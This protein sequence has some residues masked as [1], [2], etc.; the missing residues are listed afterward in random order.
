MILTAHSCLVSR[1][2]QRWTTDVAPLSTHAHTTCIM[3]CL[4]VYLANF[5]P[6]GFF[7]S[8]ICWT[9][10]PWTICPFSPL[11]WSSI[12]STVV[13]THVALDTSRRGYWREQKQQRVAVSGGTRKRAFHFYSPG[14]GRRSHAAARKVRPRGPVAHAAT[15]LRRRS[16]AA[17][18][19][20]YRQFDD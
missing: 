17:D 7:N 11:S 15:H 8:Q 14:V 9:I 1:S 20:V 16:A 18:A 19:A 5:G 4:L 2:T 13:N 3:H 6:F 10:C 12:C